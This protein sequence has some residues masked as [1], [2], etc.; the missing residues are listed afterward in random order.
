MKV[1][2]VQHVIGDYE[3]KAFDNYNLYVSKNIPDNQK[4][5]VFGTV[6][7]TINVNGKV[8]GYIKVK[9]SVL[10][11]VCAADKIE[12]LIGREIEPSFDIYG[13]CKEIKVL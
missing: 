3:G 1:I 7:A 5:M 9:A 12:K 2:G 6:P 13:V 10:H 11:E 8:K 4:A